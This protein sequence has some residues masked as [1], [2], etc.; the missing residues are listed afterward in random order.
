MFDLTFS[1]SEG[2]LAVQV[3]VGGQSDGVVPTI[4]QAD[5]HTNPSHPPK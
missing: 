3:P 5:D 4:G 2:V 1:H